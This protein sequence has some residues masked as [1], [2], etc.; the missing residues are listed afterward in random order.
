MMNWIQKGRPDFHFAP[1][2]G[3]INDPN[4]LIYDGEKYHLFAQHN[5]A[6]TVWGPM[7]WLHATSRDLL[8][9][10]ESGIALYPCDLGMMFSGCAVIDSANTAGFGKDAM[11]LIFTLHGETETQGLAYSSDGIHFSLYKDNPVIKNPGSPDFRDPKV[12]WHTADAE[13][14]LVLAAGSSLQFYASKDLKNWQ[15]TGEFGAAEKGPNGVYECPDLFSLKT[16]DGDEKW[17]LL[18]S[19]GAPPD[20]GGERIQYFIGDYDGKI[21]R[22]TEEMCRLEAGK[23]NYAGATFSGT[24]DR[25]FLGWA[26]LP[27][28]AGKVPCGSYRG[29]FTL[30]RKLSLIQTNVGL[31]LSA[32]PV[33]PDGKALKIK[34]Y[35]AFEVSLS[36]SQGDDFTFGLSED[37][38]FYTDRTKAGASDFDEL[39]AAPSYGIT[40][41]PRLMSGPFEMTLIIDHTLAEIFADQGTYVNTTLLFPTVPYTTLSIRGEAE[42]IK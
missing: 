20:K 38:F 13:W 40:K 39:F 9:F 23:D 12:F 25:L 30:P 33:F 1:K 32:E 34:A 27:L 19:I 17:V 2:N 6:D 35:G 24:N 11:V 14:K 37:N 16:P 42:E 4:G 10:E 5:P 29:C 28:Y 22:R 41:T 8:H 36:N 3:W 26:A 18:A 15:K 31:R 7:H 21:F